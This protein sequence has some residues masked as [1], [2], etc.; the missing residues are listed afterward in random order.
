MILLG[1]GLDE[2]LKL[3][4]QTFV[5]PGDEVIIPIPTFPRYQLEIEIMGGEAVLLGLGERFELPVEAILDRV[6]A[7]TKLIFVCTPNNPTGVP[8]S[9]EAIVR[10]LQVDG[11]RPLV[12]VDEALIFPTE[13]GVMDLVAD[14]RN[15]MV[16]RTFSKSYGLAGARVGYAVGNAELLAYM[17][18]IRPPFNVNLLGEAAVLGA[19]ADPDFLTE[20][21][22]ALED[23]RLRLISGL[24]PLPGLRVFPSETSILMF[25][26]GG[27]GWSSTGV[28]EALARRGVIVVDCRSYAGL[29]HEDY[30]R[31][32]IGSR[33]DNERF[34]AALTAILGG[35]PA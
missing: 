30:I 6:S 25:D 31:I 12:V 13:M 35:V 2:V 26:V 17:E 22:A 10:L 18:V 5:E 21:R 15:L 8:V 29:E 24:E 27:T 34:L 23:E 20:S 3:I 4:A 28:T 7:R 33:R 19:L 32:A 16:L 11:E 1:D 14:H 9:R